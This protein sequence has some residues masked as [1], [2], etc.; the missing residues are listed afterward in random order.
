MV[1]ATRCY[2]QYVVIVLFMSTFIAAEYKFKP[3][4]Q[5][6]AFHDIN[7]NVCGETIPLIPCQ[8]R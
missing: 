2:V 4:V 7:D 6:L 3:L 5:E 1:D 8:H